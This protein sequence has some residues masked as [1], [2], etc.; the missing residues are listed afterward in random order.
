MEKLKPFLEKFRKKFRN[1]KAYSKTKKTP[2]VETD[3]LFVFS[4]DGFNQ[5]AGSLLSLVSYAV[6]YALSHGT[7][8]FALHGRFFNHFLIL[9]GNSSPAN[10]MIQISN[11]CQK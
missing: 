4:I 6:C 1:L 11:W 2:E 10:Q 7:L 9:G 3:A 5:N 8:G